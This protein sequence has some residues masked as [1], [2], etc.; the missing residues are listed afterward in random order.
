[1]ALPRL[2]FLP[3]PRRIIP[4]FSLSIIPP[5]DSI[6]R[7][8]LSSSGPLVG[9]CVQTTE[10]RPSGSLPPEPR[11]GVE[12]QHVGRG[13]PCNPLAGVSSIGRVAW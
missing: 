11:T 3:R 13:R 4:S 5:S 6:L 12:G 8:F 1:M 9:R 10:L 2:D 7:P